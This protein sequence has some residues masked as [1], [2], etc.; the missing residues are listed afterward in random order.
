MSAEALHLHQLEREVSALR[1]VAAAA[2]ACR[3]E[4][5][6]GRNMAMVSGNAFRALCAAL[7][8]CDETRG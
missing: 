6:E 4:A 1:A 7:D 3:A 5:R 8:A 2:R